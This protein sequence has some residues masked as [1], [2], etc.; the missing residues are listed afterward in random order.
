MPVDFQIV[1]TNTGQTVHQ[2][3]FVDLFFNPT[4]VTTTTIPITN[5]NGYAGFTYFEVGTSKIITITSYLG[6]TEAITTNTVY[7]MVDS[8]QTIVESNEGNNITDELLVEVSLPPA[9]PP[10]PTPGVTPSPTPSAPNAQT[11]VSGIVRRLEGNWLPQFRAYV[12]LIEQISGNPVQT[13]ETD[14]SGYY[15]FNN[16]PAGSYSVKACL[17]LD[18]VDYVGIRS[19]I[20]PIDP[21]ANVYMLPGPC[22]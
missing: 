14:S 22:T 10:L 15:E 20:I 17:R 7:V 8:L 16:V 3:F 13:A 19:G 1:M 4:A 6:F 2:L 9:I 11:S 12:I 18:G 21:F 5:S